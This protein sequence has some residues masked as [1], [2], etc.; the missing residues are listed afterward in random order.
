MKVGIITQPLGRNYGGILQ[1]WALQQIILRLGHRPV[2]ITYYGISW[3]S[4][5]YNYW[6]SL[7]SY[8]IKHAI[9]HPRRK[10][11]FKPW[12]STPYSTLRKFVAK[13]IKKTQFMPLITSDVLLKNGITTLILGSDQIWRPKYNEGYLD[14][15]FC[16]GIDPKSEINCFTYAASFGSG[17]WE[18]SREETLLATKNIT[19]FKS[20]SVR[21]ESGVGLCKKYLN[22]SSKQVLDPTL[23]LNKQDYNKFVNSR[24]LSNIPDDCIGV[25]FLDFNEDKKQ[26][27]NIVCQELKKRPYY[28]GVKQ[29]KNGEY[30]AIE[31]WLSTYNKCP[32]IVT[33][34]FHGTVFSII[35]HIPFISVANIKRGIDR[36]QSV[37]SIVKL[38]DRLVFEGDKPKTVNCTINW[39]KVDSQIEML[40]EQSISFLTDNI[41]S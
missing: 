23:L 13:N 10:Q 31:E 24:T 12:V 36:F 4:R 6:Y 33:D 1:N 38:T 37:L 14:I 30:Q 34:S 7:F 2:N 39:D 8:I 3:K 15:M 18:Y 25:Y 27:V 17:A 16:N 35:Y 40:R 5:I 22:A 28:F 19:K 21:E 11:A 9:R 29:G 20:I 26:I 41:N 32:F